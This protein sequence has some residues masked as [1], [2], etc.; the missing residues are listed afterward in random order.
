MLTDFH[1]EEAKKNQNGRLKKL[2][3]S[4]PQILNF[5]FA[6]ISRIGL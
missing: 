5:L 3:F 2:R 1:E 6:K 4:T